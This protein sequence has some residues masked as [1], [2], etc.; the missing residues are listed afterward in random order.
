ME[1]AVKK[2]T[3]EKGQS[4]EKAS[5]GRRKKI[6]SIQVLYITGR[7]NKIYSIQVSK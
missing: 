2:R 7:R 5:T 3:K 1:T 6:Y 4:S